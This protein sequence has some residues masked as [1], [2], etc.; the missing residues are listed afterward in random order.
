MLSPARAMFWMAIAEAAWPELT[1][2]AA[3]PPS[4]A[5]IR[6]SS[7]AQVGFMIRL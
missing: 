1:A 4:S 6:S 2:R 7:T 3:A 5:A